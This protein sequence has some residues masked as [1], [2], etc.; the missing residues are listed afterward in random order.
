MSRTSALIVL[1]TAA[2]ATAACYAKPSGPTVY[3]DPCADSTYV[4]LKAQPVDS[5][6]QR[7]YETFQMLERNCLAV[8]RLVRG[9]GSADRA[10]KRPVDLSQIKTWTEPSW[11][12]SGQDIYFR[13]NGRFRVWITKIEL[14]A[15]SNIKTPC[16]PR[17]LRVRLEPGESQ[18]VLTVEF[19]PSSTGSSYQYS[20]EVQSGTVH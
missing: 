9:D 4:A 1:I 7:E 10:P 19:R 2:A 6:S 8:Q 16:G 12:G 20:Y 18:R 14:V 5:L 13:N 11:T 15:C 3:N 17:N